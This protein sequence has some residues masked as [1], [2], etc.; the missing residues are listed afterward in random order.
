MSSKV[1]D[2]ARCYGTNVLLFCEVCKANFCH[3]CFESHSHQA[4]TEYQKKMKE[5]IDGLGERL[6]VRCVYYPRFP[7]MKGE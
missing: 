4:F 2:C 6:G 1:D 7:G 3:Y 5:A